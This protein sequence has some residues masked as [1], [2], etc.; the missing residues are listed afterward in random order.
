MTTKRTVTATNTH[1][2]YVTLG[3]VLHTLHLLPYLIFRTT[4]GG[5]FYYHLCFKDEETGADSEN[6]T[7]F[8]TQPA[9]TESG[10]KPRL[11][12]STVHTFNHSTR[13]KSVW[14]TRSS[15]T[16]YQ[17][18]SRRGWKEGMNEIILYR[19]SVDLPPCQRLLVR[20]ARALLPP[21]RR[22]EL[23]RH[24]ATLRPQNDHPPRRARSRDGDSRA[25][26]AEMLPAGV[27]PKPGGDSRSLAGI[28]GPL[29]P[30]ALARLAAAPHPLAPRGHPPNPG[31]LPIPLPSPPP[32]NRPRRPAA[33]HPSPPPPGSRDSPGPGCLLA[34]TC[35]V[36]DP[37]VEGGASR[38]REGRGRHFTADKGRRHVRVGRN[39]PRR[40][41]GCNFR[42][43]RSARAGRGPRTGACAYLPRS[44]VLHSTSALRIV[45][46]VTLPWFSVPNVTVT[47]SPRS[48]LIVCQALLSAL[49]A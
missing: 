6:L 29:A 27:S 26:G 39:R 14:C 45:L 2:I 37:T 41:P 18:P 19:G 22:R 48:A 42:R 4:L 25:A 15:L 49:R 1:S 8:R 11:P 33:P 13:I 38:P 28:A 5:R 44:S 32:H 12:G 24:R 40:L 9:S 17:V 23:P 35:H 10:S 34:L 16:T 36:P 43:M 20:Q 3:R 46:I 21:P 30:S 47:A 7:C 31:S